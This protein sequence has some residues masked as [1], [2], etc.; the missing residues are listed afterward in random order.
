MPLTLRLIQRDFIVSEEGVRCL[1]LGEIDDSYFSETIQNNKPS[2]RKPKTRSQRYIR[3][4]REFLWQAVTTATATKNEFEKLEYLRVLRNALRSDLVMACI[5]VDS[6]EDAFQIFETLNDRGLRLSVPDLLLN[7]LMRVSVQNERKQVRKVWDEM[8]TGM[9]RRDIGRFLRHLWVSRYGEL[10]NVGLFPALKT[11]IA[12]SSVSSLAFVQACA[13]ECRNYVALLDVDKEILG[14]DAAPYVHSLLKG[15]DAQSALPLLLSA[16][17]TFSTTEFAQIVKWLLIF[18]TR[19]SIL[20]GLDSS[21]LETEL[22]G[23]ARS[24][25]GISDASGKIGKLSAPQIKSILQSK[26][27]TD[28][29]IIAS[30][31]RLV[32]PAESTEYVVRR[33][34]DAM[35][36]KTK[37]KVTARE[38]NL[39]HIY[40]QNPEENGWGGEA[41]QALLEPLGT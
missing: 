27:P 21:G 9:G 30:V 1:E 5:N 23:L 29:Q 15:I 18:V 11:Q 41:N 39:E 17:A 26:A 28:S 10:K 8:L 36:S 35:E 13:S 24:V 12:Q 37:E 3:E 4:A 34:S 31:E 22:F 7:Y 25:R 6:D 2:P 38:S 40:P 32:L 16:F 14:A 19:W 20:M 33:V